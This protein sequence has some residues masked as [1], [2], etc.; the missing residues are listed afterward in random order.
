VSTGSSEDSKD[1]DM[2]ST[3][4]AG[5]APRSQRTALAILGLVAAIA[6]GF[7]LGF[8]ANQFLHDDSVTP[9]AGSVDVG[10]AQDMIEHHDQAVEMSA[11]AI[12]N[13]SDPLVRDFAYDLLT[14]Q[15]NQIGQMTDEHGGMDHGTGTAET[16]AATSGSAQM[17]GMAT[18]AEMS[19]L[20]QARGE[21]ADVM[22]LQ[23]MLRHHQGGL[24]MMEY[25]A[26]N[27]E[28]P[29]VRTLAQTMV[30]TQASETTRMTQMLAEKG[31]AP[32]PFP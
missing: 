28:V 7:G 6:V 8:L 2:T 20:R 17:P 15:Q 9:V 21:A 24:Q 10:F 16:E 25:A 22:F 31:A 32:L 11:I 18:S 14:T 1:V 23:L 19:A 29:A 5:S 26:Q 27:A 4:T 3:D 30:N 13:A 12:A